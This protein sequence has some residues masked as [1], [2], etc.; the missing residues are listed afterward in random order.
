MRQSWKVSAK[1]FIFTKSQ[2]LSALHEKKKFK[3]KGN[4][5]FEKSYTLFK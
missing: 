2:L 1:S 5:I 3:L 4:Q